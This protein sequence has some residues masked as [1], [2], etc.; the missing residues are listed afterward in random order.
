MGNRQVAKRGRLPLSYSACVGSIDDSRL[1]GWILSLSK[2][3]LEPDC[4]NGLHR[5]GPDAR[6]RICR[7]LLRPNITQEACGVPV[8]WSIPIAAPPG[9]RIDAVL[10]PAV[11]LMSQELVG[12]VDHEI[13][14]RIEIR[15]ADTLPQMTAQLVSSE[16]AGT[17]TR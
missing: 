11:D 9:H 2:S 8:P 7:E 14:D 1:G 12:S 4:S 16:R 15:V 3:A 5:R 17:R 13:E 6:D 10:P